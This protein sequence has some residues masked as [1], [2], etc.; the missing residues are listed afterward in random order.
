MNP[1]NTT[2]YDLYSWSVTIM[3]DRFYHY[4]YT[5]VILTVFFVLLGNFVNKPKKTT[6]YFNS[7]DKIS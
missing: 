7:G 3:Q 5:Y 4:N 2:G 1:S 6:E